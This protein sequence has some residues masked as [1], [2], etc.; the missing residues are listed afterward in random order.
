MAIVATVDDRG[1]VKLP[2]GIVKP[3]DRVLIINAGS[4]LVLIPIPPRPLE[5]SSGWIK[6]PIDRRKAKRIA[7]EAALSE[8]QAKL[9][10]RDKGAHRD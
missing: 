7:D 10:R 3:G 5:F 1:R 8:V 6:A 2:K 9:E 4:R